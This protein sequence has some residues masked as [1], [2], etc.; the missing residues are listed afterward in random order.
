VIKKVPLAESLILTEENAK[1]LEELNRKDG[2]PAC[3]CESERKEWSEIM[4]RTLIKQWLAD[5]GRLGDAEAVR[6]AAE[7][8]SEWES[9]ESAVEG[10]MSGISGVWSLQSVKGGS[11]LAKSTIL[12]AV[13]RLLSRS[14]VRESITRLDENDNENAC[15]VRLATEW[16]VTRLIDGKVPPRCRMMGGLDPIDEDEIVRLLRR[17]SRAKENPLRI[18]DEADARALKPELKERLK[19]EDRQRKE[20]EPKKSSSGK[21]PEDIWRDSP[22]SII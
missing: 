16:A 19:K 15:L 9:N 13:R 11:E 21:S 1:K 6:L 3:L 12:P 18:L 10:V 17:A 22:G 8:A 14:E 20:A 7:I 4:K 2:S 5:V